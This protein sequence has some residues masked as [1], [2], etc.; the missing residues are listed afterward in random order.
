MTW[1]DY[2][3]ENH[4]TPHSPYAD[5]IDHLIEFYSETRPHASLEQVEEWADRHAKRFAV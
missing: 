3:K 5:I 2:A 4:V 1:T